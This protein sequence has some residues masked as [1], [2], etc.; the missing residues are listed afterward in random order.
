MQKIFLTT[1]VLLTIGINLKAQD[2]LPAIAVKNISGKIIV[3]WKNN[4]GAYISNINIQRSTDSL[5]NFT[6]I[7]TVLEPMNRENGFVDNRPGGEKM[8][9]RV[10]VAFEGGN[11]IFSKSKKP[12]KDTLST[13][14]AK[15]D[16]PEKILPPAPKGFV[17]SKHIYT[18]KD[19]HVVINLPDAASKKYAVKFFDDNGNA[20]FELKQITEPYLILEKVNFVRS[21]WYHFELFLNG[22]TEEKHKFF[23]PREEKANKH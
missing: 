1:L 16:E 2:T 3:S 8:Y 5:R 9:Y 13:L 12:V 14:P 10:F 17:A 6:T 23:I 18:G 22:E 20:L 11:Y 21:G 15:Y 4:Y 19:N 7:G